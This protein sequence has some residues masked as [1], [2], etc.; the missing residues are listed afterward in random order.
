MKIRERMSGDVVVL[1]LSGD[2]L[3][4]EDRE[5][6]LYTISRLIQ[7]GERDIILEMARVR[8]INSLGLGILLNAYALALRLCGRMRMTGLS[9][10]IGSLV[11]V[12]RLQQVFEVMPDLQTAKESL[13]GERELL[14]FRW[15]D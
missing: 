7:S 8:R 5:T 6:L 11:F 13:Q 2:I 1:E 3:G 12:T 15:A 9:A 4:A 10:R 14:A